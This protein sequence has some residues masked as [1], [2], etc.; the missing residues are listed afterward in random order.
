MCASPNQP[1]NQPAAC[2]ARESKARVLLLARRE[3]GASLAAAA[4]RC[5]LRGADSF[6]RERRCVIGD[7]GV[8]K[9]AL[10]QRHM[11]DDFDPNYMPT[12]FD[13][14]Q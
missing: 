4:A 12:I 5:G 7:G 14:Y 9:T 10:L 6:P 11:H 13:D 3:A 2:R 8:G 1:A